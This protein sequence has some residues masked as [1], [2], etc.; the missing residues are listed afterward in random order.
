VGYRIRRLDTTDAGSVSRLK[1]SAPDVH[2]EKVLARFPRYYEACFHLQSVE[3]LLDNQEMILG[4]VEGDQLVGML[5]VG[6]VR[7]AS[8]FPPPT[9]ETLEAIRNAF[10]PADWER[11]LRVGQALMRTYIKAPTNSYEIHSLHVLPSHR[12]QGIASSLLDAMLCELK[13]ELRQGLFVET[14]RVN[15]L[16][17]LYES[18]GFA[19]VRQ[20]FS[21]V[22]RIRFGVWGSMLLRHP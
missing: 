6:R 20:T 19:Y 15:H 2:L 18:R 21:F 12:R 7:E 13:P 14:A 5:A 4:A 1:H 3:T 8:E 9:E 22:E 11:F 16:R 17:R 10:T